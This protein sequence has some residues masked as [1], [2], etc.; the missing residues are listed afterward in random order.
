MPP[1]PRV[2]LDFADW[3]ARYTLSSAGHGAAH[4]DERGPRLLAAGA[5][6]WRAAHEAQRPVAHDAGPRPRARGGG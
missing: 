5:A 6:L 3:V 4:D 1:L 2:S